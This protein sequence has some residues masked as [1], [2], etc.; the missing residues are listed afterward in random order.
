M[1]HR[2]HIGYSILEASV[3]QSSRDGIPEV[4]ERFKAI[5]DSGKIYGPYDAGADRQPIYR[6]K[7]LPTTKIRRLFMLLSS[8]VGVCKRRQF[9]AALAVVLA[10]PPLARGNPAWGSHKT[11]CIH[12]HEYATAR[13]RPFKGRGK[14]VEPPRASHQCLAC[15]REWHRTRRFST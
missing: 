15:V 2:T 5:V 1:A 11:H 14:N 13:I 12:G 7:L 8:Q 10:Q 4:L 6:W 9:E 3:T